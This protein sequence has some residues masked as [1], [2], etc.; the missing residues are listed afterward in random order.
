MPDSL[1]NSI[2]RGYSDLCAGLCA[3]SVAAQELQIWKEV[4]GIFTAD[5]S[6]I[7]SARLLPTVTSEEAAELTYY[8]SEVIHPLT[9]E[10]LGGANIPLRLKNV[11]NPEGHGTI[12]FPSRSAT[13]TPSPGSSPS[14]SPNLSPTRS[15]TDMK[16]SVFMASN[17]YYGEDQRRRTPTAVTAEDSITIINVQS[18]G[19][20]K[21]RGF[22]GKVAACLDRREVIVHLMCSSNQSLSFAVSY[23]GPDTEEDGIQR[24]VSDLEEVGQVTVTKHMSIISVVGHKLRNVVGVDGQIFSALATAQISVNLISQGASEISISFVVK[25][26]DALRAM[27]MVHTNVMRIPSHGDS[28]GNLIKG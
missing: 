22:I 26:Q 18:N 7:E 21:P 1:L 16:R 2:G 12:I 19:K 20:T 9:I 17:G 11:K 13:P 3:V 28:V 14:S 25:A 15:D 6:K 5:P 24:A 27:E 8:G 4:D 10:Q 23:D